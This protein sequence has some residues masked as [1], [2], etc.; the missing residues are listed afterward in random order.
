MDT[1]KK[2]K[3]A[4]EDLGDWLG[5]HALTMHEAM[6]IFSS[7]LAYS[8]I[9]SGDPAHFMKRLTGMLMFHLERYEKK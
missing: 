4:L 6:N 8:A 7:F 5:K 3:E 9:D 2:E 1:D